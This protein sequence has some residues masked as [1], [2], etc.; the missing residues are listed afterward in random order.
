MLMCI[1]GVAGWTRIPIRIWV[2]ISGIVA[3]ARVRLQMVE[4][5]PFIRNATVTLT[6]TPYVNVSAVPLSRALPNVLD[7]PFVSGFVQSSIAAACQMYTAPQ[8]ITMNLAQLLLGDGTKKDT[9]AVGV[10]QV[11][12]HH[13]T[14]LAAA[15]SN[16]KSDPYVVAAWSKFGKPM[17][18]TRVMVA[19]LNPVWEET[20]F[21]LVTQDEITSEEKL[22]IQLWD[23]DA[24]SADDVLGR[25]EIDLLQIMKDAENKIVRR[26][27]KMRGF[28][29]S[30]NM[31]GE[32]HWSYGFYRK[33]SLESHMKE[34]A[35]ELR[36]NEEHQ[37]KSTPDMQP[38]MVDTAVEAQALDT[39][40]NPQFPSGVFS[41]I[42]VSRP[43]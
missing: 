18:S 22:S 30:E 36:S 9:A 14:A 6:G 29:E 37:E 31:P 32:V 33:V 25:V 2:E 20:F 23:S 5:M 41:I 35:D 16:G 12:I 27:D 1:S 3:T 42:I 40:P 21:L 15:D 19:D 38:T 39:P 17:Y 43:F 10:L 11:T 7:L 34:K 8:S 24:H 13:A 26:A 4:Q 28:E